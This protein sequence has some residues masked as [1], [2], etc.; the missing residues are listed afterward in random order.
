M[1]KVLGIMSVAVALVL[2][3]CGGAENKAGKTET[4]TKVVAKGETEK[5]KETEK[6]T[7]T[8]VVAVAPKPLSENP[9]YQKGLALIAGSDC[10][11]CH[12]TSEKLIGPAYKDV[13]A[14]YEATES[15]IKMLAGKVISGGSGVWGA[16]PMTP[17]PQVK[18]EDAIAMVKYIM[19][20]KK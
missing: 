7:E 6:E 11:T 8:K 15:N 4:E 3:A 20:L 10:L 14:K 1:K 16:I 19:L 2:T 12:K 13:A 17:H 5:E 18:E 9:D